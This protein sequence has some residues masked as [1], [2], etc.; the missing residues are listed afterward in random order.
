MCSWRKASIPIATPSSIS[1]VV[2]VRVVASVV[3]VI[4][5][6][7]PI[8]VGIAAIEGEI[9]RSFNNGIE[10]DSRVKTCR[11]EFLVSIDFKDV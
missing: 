4:R 10:A 3:G 9:G 5:D 8:V 11:D 1:G 6:G 7:V 2:S